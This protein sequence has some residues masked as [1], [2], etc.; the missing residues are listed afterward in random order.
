MA[1][2]INTAEVK[3]APSSDI[4][5]TLKKLSDILLDRY[6]NDPNFD[7]EQVFQTLLG[8]NCFNSPDDIRLPFIVT[9]AIIAVP[10]LLPK[11]KSD[12]TRKNGKNVVPLIQI[13]GQEPYYAY[14]ANTETFIDQRITNLR[15]GRSITLHKIIPGMIVSFHHF[16]YEDGYRERQRIDALKILYNE[17]NQAVYEKVSEED[18]LF[19]MPAIV[20]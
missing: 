19:R 17:E 4:I 15:G 8:D 16:T 2:L 14:Q 7:I 1:K 3:K 9:D 13:P 18:A 6:L 11:K 12:G 5:A 10:S 20:E